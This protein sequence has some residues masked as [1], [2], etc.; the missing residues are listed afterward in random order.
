[1]IV[2]V[3]LLDLNR[4]EANAHVFRDFPAGVRAYHGG[5]VPFMERHLHSRSR[6]CVRY[7][8]LGIMAPALLYFPVG[9]P[10]TSDGETLLTFIADHRG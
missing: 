3:D 8:V 4:K 9:Y 6:R 2:S 5:V 7:V 10:R 1:M